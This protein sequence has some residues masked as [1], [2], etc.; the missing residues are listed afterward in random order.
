M[1]T[2]SPSVDLCA[3][4]AILLLVEA[5]IPRA[6]AAERG[7]TLPN[8]IQLPAVWP[9]NDR[10]PRLTEPMPVP[11][12]TNPPAVI[13]IDV[14]RQLFVDDFLIESSDLVRT[15]H[16]AEKHPGNPVFKA[17]TSE[18]LKRNST[19]YLD[20]GG[21]FFDPTAKQFKMFY[22]AGWRGPLAMATSGNLV[23]WSRP[24]LRAG[25]GNVLLPAGVKWT[26]PEISRAGSDNSVWFDAQTPIEAERIKLLTCWMH[27]PVEQRPRGF[28]H[29]LQT[30]ADGFVWSAATPTV[31]PPGDDY[32]SF[33]YNPFRRVWGF[34]IKQH[35]PRGRARY[36]AESA[37]FLAGADWSRAVYWTNTDRLDEPEPAGRYPGAG[38]TP[39]LY[40][41]GAVAYES[42]M[43]GMHYIH[44]GPAN[45]VCD[46]EKIPK[47]TDL[48][49]GFSRDG[50]HWHRPDRRGFITGTRRDGD[51]DRGYLHSTTGICLVLGDKLVFPYTAYSGIAPNGGR[52]MYT[53]GSIGI[54]LLRRDGFA[55]MDAT[56]KPG[57]LT[58]RPVTFDGSR[59]FANVAISRGGELRVEVLDIDGKAIAPFS[60]GN[61]IP[62][63]TDSTLREVGWNGTSSL[64][65]LRGRPV[66]FRFHLKNGSLYAFWVSRNANGASHGYV[67]AGGPGYPGLIDTVGREALSTEP[68]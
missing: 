68:E 22:T 6:S 25:S 43:L 8:G 31:G 60:A 65:V 52:G 27:V 40:A 36:Y 29:S 15:F 64:S 30:S 63:A 19:V 66:R 26:G 53:G 13:P 56:E 48:E 59:L 24:E 46:R 61:C 50:F 16:R 28:N 51:W 39:Q 41:L 49:L 32:C 42:L 5:S 2:R 9:P 62:I 57:T 23:D 67:G 17:Q 35:G 1:R 58:T 14:G 20:Q 10:D 7:A 55:S 34:S 3:L 44:R 12:L 38:D 4:G 33:F 54:A 47:L 37:D 11:Y 45:E 21:V 18:E